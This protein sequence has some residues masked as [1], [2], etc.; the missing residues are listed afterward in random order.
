MQRL[1][2]LAACLSSLAAAGLVVACWPPGKRGVVL[3]LLALTH[4]G[5]P[6]Q[7]VWQ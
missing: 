7:S 2:A 3:I 5:L 6:F 4:I 1:H